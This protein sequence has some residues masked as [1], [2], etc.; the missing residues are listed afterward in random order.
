MGSVLCALAAQ[1]QEGN[2]G[3]GSSR[4]SR[5]SVSTHEII[6]ARGTPSATAV[7][8]PIA[9]LRRLGAPVE[10]AGTDSKSRG[11]LEGAIAPS[12]CRQSS[13]TPRLDARIPDKHG[14]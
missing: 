10:M 5:G 11:V 9:S 14:G 2:A 7:P 8:G 6:T 3:S 1:A 13:E 12:A 4:R